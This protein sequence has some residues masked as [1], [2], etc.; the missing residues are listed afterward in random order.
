MG[1]LTRFSLGLVLIA[2]AACSAAPSGSIGSSAASTATPTAAP[3]AAATSA[4]PAV[5]GPIPNTDAVLLKNGFTE[6]PEGCTRT[7]GAVA[8]CRQFTNGTL[9]VELLANGGLDAFM[10]SMP[11][12]GDRIK[13]TGVLAGLYSAAEVAGAQAAM[14]DSQCHGR[15]ISDPVNV[16]NRQFY[17]ECTGNGAF[18]TLHVV[19]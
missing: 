2:L 11:I 9:T 1:R 14:D 5:Y 7:A 4:P 18:L 10:A 8:S 17:A 16:G 3:T 15:G 19:H 12:Q 6:N 13:L